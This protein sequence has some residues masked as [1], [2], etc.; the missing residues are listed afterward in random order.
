MIRRILVLLGLFAAGRL[1]FALYN[2]EEAAIGFSVW[3]FLLAEA[4]ALPLD[5][6]TAGA[7]LLIPAL[8]VKAPRWISTAYYVLLALVMTVVTM[9]DAVLYDFWQFHLSSVIISYALCP[10]GLTS[11]VD[12]SFIVTRVAAFVVAL[13]LVTAILVRQK[14]T[15]HWYV[16]VILVF[17]PVGVGSC[18]KDGSRLF[19]N[20]TATNPTYAFITSFRTDGHYDY[21]KAGQAL[22]IVRPL[23]NAQDT[24]LTDTLL[25]CRR[26]N[27]LIVQME[28][29]GARFVEELGGL[30]DVAPQLGRLMRE[31]I[32]F[33]QYYSNSFR[34]DR[35]SV[36]LQSGHVVPPTVSLMK[37][38]RY[39]TRLA[40]LAR[41]LGREG[42]RTDYLYPGTLDNMG[43]EAYYTHMGY[44]TLH[45]IDEFT[46]GERDCAWGSHDG[47]SARH[48][49]RMLTERTD[50]TQP[51]MMTYQMVSSHEPWHVPYDRLED[52]KLNAFAY[53]DDC[54]GWLVDTLRT[55]PLWDNLLV[56]V[57]PDHG[58]L[59]KQ[60]YEDPQFFHAPMIWV[61]GAVAAS[62]TVDVLMNQ[63]DVA[64]TLL[65]QMGIPHDDFPWSRNVLGR[66]YT[67]PF[68]YCCFPAGIMLVEPRGVTIH[69]I[70]ADKTIT[71]QP[72][73]NE[74]R[75]L[76]A[77]AILQASYLQ[78][79][80]NT[81]TEE[82][83]Q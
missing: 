17:L 34:T 9:A 23:Y 67:A 78:L 22:D 72:L 66:T 79:E 40:S 39:H 21:M 15:R 16:P 58:Y 8:L 62:H 83:E 61:G 73:P 42:Y 19:W 36:A 55:T 1:G 7:M 29:L 69:D 60:T 37:E 10:D 26:P 53:T 47:T 63:S 80:D 65:S 51:W 13:A 75:T 20:H 52:E 30:P 5:L 57:L 43:K 48:V 68:A 4:R 12:T 35:G 2:A 54:V 27:I 64:A 56:I 33:T 11:S 6:R 50:S 28:S 77:K 3:Q 45:C 76:T 59:Y 32:S 46:D 18:Y 41:A 71:D 14:G 31:G 44:D 25:T 81:T 49:V 38:E 24:T 70:T 74:A 82:K